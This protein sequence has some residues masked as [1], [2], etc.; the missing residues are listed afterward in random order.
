[1][2]A[3]F[4][5]LPG[6]GIGPEV[7]DAALQV[8]EQVASRYGHQ[9]ATMQ[10]PIGGDAIDRCGRALPPETREL[11]A[12][13][14]AVLLGAVGG[15]RWDHTGAGERPEQ[16][17]LELRQAL[18]VYANLRPIKPHPS[19]FA[20]SPLKAER[21]QGVDMIVV[22]ELTGGLY[23]GAKQEGVDEASDLCRYQRYEI[24][25]VV[26]HA[27]TLARHRR[28]RLCLV[29]KANVLATSRLWRKVTE[30]LIH[31]EFADVNLEIL[32]VDAAA[33]HL[34]SRPADFD[35]IVTENLFGD[36]LTDEAAML[37]GSM[38]LLPSASLGQGHCGLYEPIHGSAPDIAGQGLANPLAMILSVAMALRHSLGLGAAASAIEHAV[39]RCLDDGATTADLGGALST[40]QCARA[41]I[42]RL[43]LSSDGHSHADAA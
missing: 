21:L 28:G 9:F 5:V 39:Q 10:A 24:E 25:R 37:A 3:L 32:L 12:R 34:L 22:R 19:T 2:K 7:M 27:A 35:V 15:P 4:A 16:G 43:P 41:V 1:M 33:M 17:L 8:L 42:E 6:D 36:I 26:R 31:D 38:G 29:D 30:A 11:C 14:D 18:G 20:A 23:F 40:Q 13:A